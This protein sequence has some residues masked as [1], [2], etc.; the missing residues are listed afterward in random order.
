VPPQAEQ[1][2][3][4]PAL[5]WPALEEAQAVS[6]EPLA[7]PE[8]SNDPEPMLVAE[9]A[10][11]PP[12]PP[13]QPRPDTSAGAEAVHRA[14]ASI[15]FTDVKSMSAIRQEWMAVE[16]RRPV[17]SFDW[18]H[19]PARRETGTGASI[20]V[21]AVATTGTEPHEPVETEWISPW[22]SLPDP[23]PAEAGGFEAALA[24]NEHDR[25]ARLIREQESA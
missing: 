15:D 20:S 6:R 5:E 2:S 21:R 9:D 22:P 1:R 23:L 13:P 10:Q 11:E 25:W 4:T 16:P 17:P 14:E 7:W 18:P 24:L 8:A 12:A 3:P 19:P